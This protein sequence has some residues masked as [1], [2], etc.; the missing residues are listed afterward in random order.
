V[1]NKRKFF[2]NIFGDNILVKNLKSSTNDGIAM[3]E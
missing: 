1:K 3:N 2:A